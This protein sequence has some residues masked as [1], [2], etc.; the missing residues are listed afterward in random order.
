MASATEAWDLAHAAAGAAAVELR[1]LTSLADADAIVDVL[2]ATWGDHQ[3]VPREMIRAFAE[4]GN[5]P[6][7]AVAGDRLVGYVLGWA[8]VDAEEG[9]HVHSHM[10]AALPD[11]RHAGVGYALKLAQRAQALD[12]GVHTVRWTFD[13]LVARNAYFNLHK[14]GAVVDRFERDFYG[15]M[16]DAVNRG[17]RS[18]RFVV[19]WDLDRIPGPRGAGGR[20]GEDAVLLRRGADG[21]PEPVPPSATGGAIVEIPAEYGEL[22]ERSPRIAAAWREALAAAAE[23]CLGAGLEGTGFDRSASAYVFST[24]D[25]RPR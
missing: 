4:S 20:P 7:G 10:L 18:D 1:P 15:A 17:D 5:V 19:R 13:P 16:T 8:G 11:R 3:V 22:R 24:P 12:A 9:L 25:R 14:L 23:G 21:T 2:V 6:Y